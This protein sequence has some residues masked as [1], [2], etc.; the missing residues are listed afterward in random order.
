RCERRE[1]HHITEDR[2]AAGLEVDQV[3]EFVEIAAEPPRHNAAYDQGGGHVAEDLRKEKAYIGRAFHGGSGGEDLCFRL[4]C[5]L[6][7]FH[8]GV[9][10]KF[11]SVPCESSAKERSVEPCLYELD[12]FFAGAVIVQKDTGESR[13]GGHRVLFLDPA[14]LHAKVAGL[15]H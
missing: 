14:H 13:S 10:R 4:K 8:G 5:L 9:D 6:G 15:D 12:E 11:R 7:L 1:H 2:V 3:T